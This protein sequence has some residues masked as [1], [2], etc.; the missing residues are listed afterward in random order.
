MN[1]LIGYLTLSPVMVLS[2]ASFAATTRV[3]AAT[4]LTLEGWSSSEQENKLL[5]QIIDTFNK[6]NPDI[7]VTL[8]QVPDYDTT[9]SKDLASGTPP[10]VFCAV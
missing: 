7:Q 4:A 1:K 5:Q 6:N 9:L 3:S 8:K 10:D 2:I